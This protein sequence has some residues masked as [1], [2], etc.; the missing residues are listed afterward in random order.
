LNTCV[1]NTTGG[2]GNGNTSSSTTSFFRRPDPPKGCG[3]GVKEIAKG[4]QCDNGRFNDLGNCSFDCKLRFCGDGEVTVAVGEECEPIPTAG[5]NGEKVFEVESCGKICTAPDADGLN[6]CKVNYLAPCGEPDGLEGGQAG[7]GV[8]FPPPV[9]SGDM[10]FPPE[11][12]DAPPD[13]PVY[14]TWC[15]NGIFEDGEQC[16]DGNLMDGDGCSSGCAAEGYT[17]AICGDGTLTEGEECDDGNA[18]D[19]DGCSMMCESE[20]GAALCGNGTLED[21]EECDN[22]EQNSDT[23]PNA[24]RT[25]CRSAMCGDSVVDVTETCDEGDENSAV[26][27][28]RCRPDCQPARC[29][30]GVRDTGESCDGS[31]GCSRFCSI[32][33][34]STARCGNGTVETPEQCDDGNED[35]NDGCSGACRFELARSSAGTSFSS[36]SSF[37]I[38]DADIV[39]VNPTEIAVA[40]RFLSDPDPCARITASGEDADALAIRTQAAAQ[41]IPI[42]KFIDLARDLRAH[43]SVGSTVAG[44]ICNEINRLKPGALPLGSSARSS[45]SMRSVLPVAAPVY[46]PIAAYLPT[47]PHAPAGET[48]PGAITLIGAGAAGAVGWIR[49]RKLR[50]KNDE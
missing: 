10:T 49:R 35:P 3:N 30:D 22:A 4:E 47:T 19:G 44:K 42:V 6:G 23:T 16:D 27:A 38:L 1:Q 2:G 25:T 29:G 46:A 20:Q 7:G 37:S 40:L 13:A 21:G 24:C 8:D 26:I 18:T 28:D 14:S 36:A 15:G 12:M 9:D 31:L 5:P 11:F 50:I 41:G 48:G 39:L 34:F 33:A 17:V 43:H 45:S 32:F